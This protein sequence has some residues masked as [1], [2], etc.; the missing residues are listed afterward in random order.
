ML[1]ELVLGEAAVLQITQELAQNSTQA[2]VLTQAEKTE[3][4]RYVGLNPK[5]SYADNI[6]KIIKYF[7]DNGKLTITSHGT[8]NKKKA[9]RYTFEA[10]GFTYC[11]GVLVLNG[12]ISLRLEDLNYDVSKTNIKYVKWMI[13]CDTQL[14]TSKKARTAIKR[15]MRTDILMRGTIKLK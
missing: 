6:M 7:V 12:R 15:F 9:Y 10:H 13:R 5:L 14:M 2:P 8:H 4:A 3:A 11:F 1:A